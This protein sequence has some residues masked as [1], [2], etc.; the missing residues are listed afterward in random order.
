MVAPVSLLSVHGPKV[1]TLTPGSFAQLVGATAS[2]VPL[3]HLFNTRGQTIAATTIPGRGNVW[4]TLKLRLI[5]C[6]QVDQG[7]PPAAL[8]NVTVNYRILGLNQSQT[9]PLDAP[10]A[11]VCRR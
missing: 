11:A 2:N 5:P 3:P 1:G 4:I 6:I 7:P 8:D 10:P 9:I